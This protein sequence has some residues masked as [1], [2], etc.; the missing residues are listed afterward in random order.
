MM[1]TVPATTI[2]DQAGAVRSAA[3]SSAAGDSGFGR[4]A[5]ASCPPAMAGELVLTAVAAAIILRASS[6]SI[7]I[8]KVDGSQGILLLPELRAGSLDLKL[9]RE[10]VSRNA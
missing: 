7:S 2:G 4:L 8:L 1:R 3:A 6:S 10:N 5:A 9:G